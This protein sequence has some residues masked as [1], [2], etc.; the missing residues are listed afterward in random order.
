MALPRKSG[1]EPRKHPTGIA[2]EYLVAVGVAQAKRIHIALGVVEI[3][4]GL[5][6]DAAHRA[7]H[8]RAENDVVDRDDL[9]QELDAR[10]MID[11]AIAETSLEQLDPGPQPAR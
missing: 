11:A 9:D 10:P 8:L 6:V 4:S 3:L 1:I 5:G 7:H 2:F